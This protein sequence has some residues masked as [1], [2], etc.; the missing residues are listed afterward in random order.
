LLLNLQA[1]NLNAGLLTES[2]TWGALGFI[3]YNILALEEDITEDGESDTS[4][5]LNTTEADGA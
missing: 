2:E 5:G 4:V 3:E 1:K